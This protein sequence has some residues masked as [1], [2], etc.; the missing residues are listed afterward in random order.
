[1]PVRDTAWPDGTPCWVDY[2]A[3]D[4]DG[5]HAFYTAVLGWT[6]E[7]GDPE[8]GGYGSCL[9]GG[10]RAAGM[11]P[12]AEPGQRPS[13]TTYFASADVA[14]TTRRV[15]DAGGAVA[16]PPVTVGSH[17][18]MAI[19]TDP[20]GNLFGLW[21]A[22]QHLGVEVYNE[23]GGLVW[24]EAAVA[25]PAAAQAFYSGVFGYAWD[26]VEGM[27]GYAVFR[28]DERP[29][30]GLGAQQPG[31]PSGWSVCFSVA[32]ADEAVATVEQGGGTV[33]L[34]AEDTE[35]GRFAVVEDPWG[36]AFSVMQE[37]AG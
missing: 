37:P 31:L 15:Q 16:V 36:A 22:D 21:Q 19:A 9:S 34:A 28:R 29:L 27:G 7:E 25:D 11:M 14:G 8:R 35:F 32:S 2:G 30:G 13:W 33:V 24:N 23:P 17:G 10:R 4:L 12:A 5:A 6:Y 3:A 20:Q 18:S 1:M 26:E